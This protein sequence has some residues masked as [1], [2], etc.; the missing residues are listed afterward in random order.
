MV[1]YRAESCPDGGERSK[2]QRRRRRG[3][4]SEDGAGPTGSPC[5][6]NRRIGQKRKSQTPRVADPEGIEAL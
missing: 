2:G 3:P 1:C 5:L 6:V 4:S